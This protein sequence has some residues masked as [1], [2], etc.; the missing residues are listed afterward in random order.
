MTHPQK[1][2]RQPW[3]D[4]T[5]GACVLLVVL[6]HVV[7]W[8]L[9]HLESP[10]MKADLWTRLNDVV[11]GIRMPLLLMLS[12][13]LASGKLTR[14]RAALRGAAANYWLYVV[15]LTVY[16]LVMP[17]LGVAEAGQVR[18]G[19][20]WLQQLVAPQTPLWYVFALATYMVVLHLLRGVHPAIVLALLT[21]LTLFI[22]PG[23]NIALKVP[24][25]AIY[26]AVGVYA[27]PLLKRV[28]AEKPWALLVAG[29]AL[30]A[31]PKVIGLVP[32]LPT[33][34]IQLTWLFG[35][36]G[37]GLFMMGAVV[38]WCVLL[39]PMHWLAW[40]G[41]HTLAIYVMH[42]P[43]LALWMWLDAQTGFPQRLATLLGPL[44]VLYPALGVAVISATALLLERLVRRG[45][46]EA[47]FGLPAGWNASLQRWEAADPRAATG[48]GP[49][50]RRA[51]A[52][53]AGERSG[54]VER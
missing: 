38:L 39:R 4:M 36:L 14:G 6:Y 21:A 46:V 47:L 48:T 53:T 34:G 41:R 13:M 16:A 33:A 35:N 26:F 18:P 11:G 25:L 43:L 20:D 44:A 9:P 29:I 17:I 12:G 19:L 23:E 24:Y 32:N 5:R 50:P 52:A 3:I 51:A 30:L 8:H 7:L 31:V 42:P 1:P 28:A 27:A 54:T 15:W 37:K 40:V 2:A 49:A 22:V 10:T 45:P